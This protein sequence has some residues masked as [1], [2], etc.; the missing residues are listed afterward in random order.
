[1]ECITITSSSNQPVVD[2]ALQSATKNH[3]IIAKLIEWHPSKASQPD[4]VSSQPPRCYVDCR[5]SQIRILA[6]V[7]ARG[8]YTLKIFVENASETTPF[9]DV[10]NILF[11]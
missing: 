2:L 4:D 5:R 7:P 1:M 3:D 9:G 10:Y 11:S 6:V 8:I